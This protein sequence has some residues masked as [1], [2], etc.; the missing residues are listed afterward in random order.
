MAPLGSLL[1]MLVLWLSCA[2]LASPASPQ[3]LLISTISAAPATLP[4]VAPQSSPSTT[5]SA[6][7]SLL[8][9]SPLS[10]SPALSPDIAPLLPSPGSEAAAPGES[11]LPIIPSSP[12]PPNPDDMLAPGPNALPPSG[13]L[14]ISSSPRVAN[15]FVGVV[16]CLSVAL[17]LVLLPVL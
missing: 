16:L 2:S 3:K 5:I 17:C 15:S 13:A 10:P 4:A 14:P 6:A 1:A 11:T 8:P 9:S 12:S 7:P